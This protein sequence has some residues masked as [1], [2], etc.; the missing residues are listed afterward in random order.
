MEKKEKKERKA[1]YGENNKVTTR[2]DFVT[3]DYPS[4]MTAADHKM[5]R[6][7]ISQ[8]RKED[9][10]FFEYQFSAVDIAA[11]FGLDTS[12]VYREAQ[13][14]VRRL[15]NCNLKVGESEKEYELLHIFKTAKYKEG[16]FTMQL[17][18]EVRRLF[19]RL[20]GH[21]T[22]APLLPILEMRNKNSIRIYELICMKLMSNFP[23]ADIAISVEVTLEELRKVTETEKTKS[24]DH[25][26]HFK[27]R[28]L[29]PS[30]KEIEEAA[31]WK[32]ICTDKKRSRRVVGFDLEI[33]TKSG[34]VVME[35]YKR[36][37]ILPPE[38]KYKQA[39]DYDMDMPLPGQ[40]SI[41]DL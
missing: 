18:D 3:A 39:T 27:E 31:D 28:V 33:W 34:Y 38:P 32:I 12:N 9:R 22:N 37:G 41:F 15:F 11:H 13:E 1:D 36:E 2:N 21:F 14:S 25:I 40:L 24:Y 16:I 6:L 5:L 35:R 20:K 7:V 26:S 17:S 30:I 19:L 29:F 8:C 4:Q 23:H 10:E